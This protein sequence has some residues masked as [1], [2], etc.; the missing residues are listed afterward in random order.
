MLKILVSSLK[1]HPY[2][3]HIQFMKTREYNDTKFTLLGIH[4]IQSFLPEEVDSIKV[5]EIEWQ[6]VKKRIPLC[7]SLL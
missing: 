4:L 1:S 3:A 6:Y 2:T 7:K 5:N